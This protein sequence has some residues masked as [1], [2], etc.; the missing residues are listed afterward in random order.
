MPR[1]ELITTVS[2]NTPEELFRTK[3]G[4]IEELL[5][6]VISS[7]KDA[8]KL[9]L[10]LNLWLIDMGVKGYKVNSSL[11]KLV[12]MLRTTIKD[13]HTHEKQKDELIDYE[14]VATKTL[15]D[16]ERAL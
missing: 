10:R 14:R 6:D 2:N 16:M 1:I 8:F 11:L 3:F 9:L 5:D 7:E 12:E 13:I 4:N 15:A